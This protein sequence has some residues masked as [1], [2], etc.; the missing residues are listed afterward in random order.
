MWR[1][2]NKSSKGE[3]ESGEVSMQWLESENKSMA[4]WHIG[5][6]VQEKFI[7]VKIFHP[8][9]AKTEE[10]WSYWLQKFQLYK[11][12]LDGGLFYLARSPS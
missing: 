9:S 3:S 4:F 5:F 6:I 1:V 11:I 7:L 12:D 8:S 2:G 10:S